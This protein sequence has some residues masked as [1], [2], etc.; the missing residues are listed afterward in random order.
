M[1]SLPVRIAIPARIAAD[2]LNGH[3]PKAP[4]VLLS[5]E[6]MGTR[7]SARIAAPPGF[8]RAETDMAITG[9]LAGLVDAM[10]HWEQESLLCRFNRARAGSWAALP[11]DFAHVMARGLAIAAE[12]DGAFDPAIG[13]LVDLWGYGPPG[14]CAR[15]APA[16][17]A[18]ALAMSGWRRLAWDGE[19]RRLRQP[20]GLALDLSGIAKGYAVDAL[21]ALLTARGLRHHLVEIG[22]ELAGQGMRPDG[23]PWW[24]DLETPPALAGAVAPLRVALHGLAVATS[25]DYVRG[26]HTIDPRTG[27]PVENGVSAVSVIAATALDADAWASALAVAGAE[28]GMALAD[29]LGLAARFVLADADGQA[30]ERLSR[31]MQAM[32]AD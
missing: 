17:V 28:A 3:D 8:D 15:P 16:D 23:D 4:I 25:G 12:S 11:P 2:V 5:G 18:T 7:W 32:L 26:A 9:W 14:P 1:A 30:D 6:T 21:S 31:A 27:Y 13:R 19:A 29:R 24:V 22:G 10:S 20:G